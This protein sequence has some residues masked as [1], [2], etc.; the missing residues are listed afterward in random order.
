MPHLRGDRGAARLGSRKTAQR[1]R[2][3]PLPGRRGSQAL[4]HLLIRALPQRRM[5]GVDGRRAGGSAPR[6]DLRWPPVYATCGDRA[7]RGARS[8][9]EHGLWPQ[10]QSTD[11]VG[12]GPD[13][14]RPTAAQRLSDGGQPHWQKRRWHS[15]SRRWHWHH[16]HSRDVEDR[17]RSACS[18][19]RGGPK[20][21]ACP[22]TRSAKSTANG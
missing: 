22:A 17:A 6:P 14:T 19:D 1:H 10:Q 13:R 8:E 5:G 16:V 12:L 20:R 9:S 18:Q 3:H 15:T 7:L 21:M 4:P 11:P 2:R